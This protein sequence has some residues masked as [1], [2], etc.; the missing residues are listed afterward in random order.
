MMPDIQAFRQ[1]RCQFTIGEFDRQIIGKKVFQKL[2]ESQRTRQAVPQCL[3][4][5]DNQTK[6]V[7]E[8]V[9]HLGIQITHV[10]VPHW[11]TR[12][13]D[14]QRNSVQI[15]SDVQTIQTAFAS[16]AFRKSDNQ[17]NRHLVC[18]TTQHSDVYACQSISSQIIKRNHV[19]G[20]NIVCVVR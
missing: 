6:S 14:D 1:C 15:L 7:S 19:P 9:R 5:P 2:P 16:V 20:L 4:G 3:L 18:Q 8:V 13:S 11:R 10:S 12:W 17:T